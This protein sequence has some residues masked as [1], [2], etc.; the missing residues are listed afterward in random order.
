MLNTNKSGRGSDCF[1]L[2]GFVLHP[3]QGAEVPQMLV[4]DHH[5]ISF[6]RCIP[7]L[8]SHV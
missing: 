1:C 4:F 6:D 7:V 5:C 2:Y 3:F 8:E